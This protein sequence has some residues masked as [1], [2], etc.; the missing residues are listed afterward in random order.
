MMS[1]GQNT[2]YVR[3]P[4]IITFNPAKQRETGKSGISYYCKVDMFYLENDTN[5]HNSVTLH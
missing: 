4:V 5:Q 1:I 3:C 2:F